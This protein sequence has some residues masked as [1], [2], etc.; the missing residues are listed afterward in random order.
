MFKFKKYYFPFRKDEKK[1]SRL[2]WP[3]SLIKANN[4][5]FDYRLRTKSG[6]EFRF[7]RAQYLPGNQRFVRIYPI[8][9]NR[10]YERGIDLRIDS[11]EWCADAPEGS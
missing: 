6:D 2:G 11:I 4:D 7:S 10:C 5:E 8:D 3:E 1:L 9:M